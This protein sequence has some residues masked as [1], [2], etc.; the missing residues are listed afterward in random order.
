[1]GRWI[2][3]IAVALLAM[4]CIVISVFQLREKGVLFHN[5]Y[6]FASKRE[7][8]GMDKRPYY[9]Q[10][11]IAFALGAAIFFCLSVELIMRTGWLYVLVW[12]LTAAVLIYAIVSSI[13]ISRKRS[14]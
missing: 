4:G 6:L 11:G 5:A 7:R 2:A 13:A 12:M 3:A 10:S 1:M 9:R 8:E 14:R